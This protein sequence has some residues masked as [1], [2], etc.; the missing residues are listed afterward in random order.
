MTSS[1]RWNQRQRDVATIIWV[2]FLM[3]SAATVVFF[4]M[5]DPEILDGATAVGWRISRSAG[6]AIGFFMFWML[7]VA[8]SVLSIFLVRTEHGA[9][10]TTSDDET[11]Q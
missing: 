10:G 5:V 9:Q 11:N 4:A 1:G 3:A 8:T 7:T 6:Y 2:S